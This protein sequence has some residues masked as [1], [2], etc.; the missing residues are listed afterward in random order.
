[1][2]MTVAPL[3]DRPGR[4]HGSTREL[5]NRRHCADREQSTENRLLAPLEPR[6][7][8]SA[9]RARAAPIA[10]TVRLGI[11]ARIARSFQAPKVA[12][13]RMGENHQSKDERTGEAGQ[14]ERRNARIGK[15][16]QAGLQQEELELAREI[17]LDRS[18]TPTVGA[19]RPA[20]RGCDPHQA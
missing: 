12:T 11:E 3:V 19:Q 5:L 2:P 16:N 13:G 20:L 17:H 6:P 7:G 14:Q 8:V 10:S 18:G 9:M 4:P 15:S 1:M